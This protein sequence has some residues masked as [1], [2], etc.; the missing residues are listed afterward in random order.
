LDHHHGLVTELNNNAVTCTTEAVAGVHEEHVGKLQTSI[1]TVC[2]ILQRSAT[3]MVDRMLLDFNAEGNGGSQITILNRL[4]VLQANLRNVADQQFEQLFQEF[5][6]FTA[7]YCNRIFT[8][9]PV[10]N[11]YSDL[12]TLKYR[13]EAQRVLCSVELKD[14]IHLEE[15]PHILFHEWNL[16]LAKYV[17]QIPEHIHLTQEMI[18][19]ESCHDER[20]HRLYSYSQLKMV[21]D[22]II[23]FYNRVAGG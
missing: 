23:V 11:L 15:L 13:R 17:G 1:R 19:E 6:E 4:T 5:M 20:I 7:T 22:A 2:N 8:K 9:D 12:F 21:Y 14:A 3:A 16:L 10:T 18:Q